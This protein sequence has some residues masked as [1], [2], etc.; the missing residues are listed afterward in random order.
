MTKLWI[1]VIIPYFN[2]GAFIEKALTSIRKQYYDHI[3]IVLIDDGSTDGIADRIKE[4][5]ENIIFLRQDNK[6]PAAARNLGI[7]HAK[8]D[9]IAF[10]DADDL[11]PEDKIKMQLER[12][13]MDA[14]ADI[15]TGRI[16]YSKLE[17]AEDVDLALAEDNTL[18]NVHLGAALI[19]RQVFEDVGLFDETLRFSEDHDWFLRAREAGMKIIVMNKV[20]LIYQ[21][22]A[23]NMT[24]EKPFHEFG[25]LKILKRSID[26][27]KLAYNKETVNLPLFS[28]YNDVK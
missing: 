12:F 26:R 6:G 15:I 2:A 23:G 4:W 22:H 11:W 9:F 20:T 1:S 17:G 3:E 24:R 28:E 14:T 21:L 13:Q 8:G 18:I 7:K 16:Q 5:G 19:R 25:M 10:L 27:R